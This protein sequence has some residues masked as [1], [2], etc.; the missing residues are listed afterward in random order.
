[1]NAP[2]SMATTADGSMD[3]Y[4]YTP[5]ETGPMEHSI[6]YSVLLPTSVIPGN[7]DMEMRSVLGVGN[8]YLLKYE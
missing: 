4:S 3:A 6:A 7:V 2:R 1:M 8:C 5:A